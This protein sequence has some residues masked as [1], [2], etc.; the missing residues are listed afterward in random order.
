MAAAASVPPGLA[1]LPPGPELGA[2]L[3]GIDVS[4]VPNARILD[5]LKAESRQL[6]HQ[7]A[8]LFAAMAE[9]GRC[10]SPDSPGAVARAAEPLPEAIHEIGP[11]LAVT[12]TSAFAEHDLAEQL[13]V[14]LPAVAAALRAGRIDRSKARLFVEHARELSPAQIARLCAELLPAA[15]GWTTGQLG[16]R[17]RKWCLSLLDPDVLRRRYQKAVRERAVFGYLNRDGTA[18]ISAS[19]LSPAE[20][21]AS[22]ERVFELARA[23]RRAGHP[24]R[25]VPDS[26]RSVPCP[27]GRVAAAVD[28]RPDHRRHARP[29]RGA[30]N[31]LE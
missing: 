4:R 30:G 16:D 6:A 23:I 31:R 13:R 12:T 14:R 15:S 9:V 8:R 22:C 26:R 28:Q 18:T 5:V 10:E 19:G 27:A 1:D 11:A 24:D 21:A 20:A 3:A 29:P 7:Q 25:L 17:L 2:L